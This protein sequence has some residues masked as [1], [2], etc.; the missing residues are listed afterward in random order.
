V[1]HRGIF[2]PIEF[3]GSG[4]TFGT[5]SNGINNRGDIV[6]LYSDPADN[7]HGFLLHEGQ[8]TSIDFPGEPFTECHC[9]NDR[10]VITG[11]YQDAAGI[12]HGFIS[13]P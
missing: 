11:L 1:R 5:Q 12:S 4:G 9:I 10:G 2:T 13:T 3:P 7:G 6:G 8:Y